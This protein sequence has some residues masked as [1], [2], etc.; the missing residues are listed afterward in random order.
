M[1]DTEM[2]QLMRKDLLIN[3]IIFGDQ[4]AQWPIPLQ[5]EWRCFSLGWHEVGQVGDSDWTTVAPL[6]YDG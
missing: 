1:R 4:C 5:G 2:G 3:G 6:L